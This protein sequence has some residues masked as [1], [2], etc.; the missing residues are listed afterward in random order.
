MS[1]YDIGAGVWVDGDMVAVRIRSTSVYI[2]TDIGDKHGRIT[3]FVG[4]AGTAIGDGDRNTA[5]VEF[6]APGHVRYPGPRKQYLPAFGVLGKRETRALADPFQQTT[7]DLAPNDL[8]RFALVVRERKL[9]GPSTMA[10]SALGRDVLLRSRL[11]C[12]SG[13]HA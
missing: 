4:Q 3:L 6:A 1:I 10:E 9:A 7:P 2:G 5:L 11:P 13:R 12:C 8:E